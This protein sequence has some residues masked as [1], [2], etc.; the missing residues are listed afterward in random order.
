MNSL[1]FPAPQ[2]SYHRNS[3]DELILIPRKPNHLDET[4]SLH[5]SGI[6]AL[7]I[8]YQ[9]SNCFMIYSHGNGCD[10]GQMYHDCLQY[11]E[12]FQMNVIAYEYQGYGI[13]NGSPSGNTCKS[14]I[15]AVYE[16]LTEQLQVDGENIVIFG[17]SIGTGPSIWMAYKSEKEYIKV[18]ALI[19]QSPYT[20]IRNIAREIAGLI[21][22][23]VPK[24]FD[25]I[26]LITKISSPIILIHGENDDI[27]PATHSHKLYNSFKGRKDN[28]ILK[29][30]PGSDHNIWNDQHDI[31]EPISDFLDTYFDIKDTE[32]I[33]PLPEICREILTMHED[34]MVQ[35]RA[36]A[37][38]FSS[39]FQ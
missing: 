2:S 31:I 38:F 16:F 35:P 34:D 39:L 11:A 10:I 5:K 8:P 33:I 29:L 3:F 13:A 30:C 1:V 28:I 7:F 21:G 23:V 22:V 24:I 15:R 36:R 4:A 18:G 20:S 14:D 26:G 17:R 25:N 6:P 19:L 32:D 27:I 37:G 12:H 9:G